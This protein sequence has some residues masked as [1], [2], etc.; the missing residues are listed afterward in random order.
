MDSRNRNKEEC[1]LPVEEIQALKDLIK[2]QSNRIIIIKPCDK[3]AGI[4]IL[5]LNSYMKSCY[6]HLLSKQSETH[7]YY[8]KVDNLELERANINIKNTL[9][10][11]LDYKIITEDGFKAMD[12]DDK[13]PGKFY[14]NLKYTNHKHMA[15]HHHPVQLS[16]GPAPLQNILVYMWKIKSMSFLPNRDH[17]YKI[18]PTF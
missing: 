15:Q 6:E 11:S 5:N 9:K 17:I 12:P 8:K 7:N 10:E 2:L 18:H 13:R 3:G 16:V 14:C 1:N 4:M